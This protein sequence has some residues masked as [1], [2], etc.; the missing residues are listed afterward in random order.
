M[1]AARVTASLL[2]LL[3]SQ[4]MP[5]GHL[6]FRLLLAF[7]LLIVGLAAAFTLWKD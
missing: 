6:P 1:F 2:V 3:W 7:L 4:S 5:G